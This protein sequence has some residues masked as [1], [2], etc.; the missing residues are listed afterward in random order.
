MVVFKCRACNANLNIEYGIK[1]VTCEF[2]GST[3]MIEK[4]YPGENLVKRGYMLL[5]DGDFRGAK[6][7]FD[8]ALDENS[9]ASEAYLGKVLVEN[10]VKKKDDFFDLNNISNV[11]EFLKNIKYSLDY[12]NAIRYAWEDDKEKLEN[13]KESVY[14]KAYDSA[15]ECMKKQD[16]PAA[17]D[18]LKRAYEYKDAPELLKE[19]EALADDKESEEKY[20][21]ALEYMKM[22]AYKNAVN[23]FDEL[24]EYKDSA[25]Q[26]KEC[27]YR[28]GE[29]HMK[30][31][32][33]MDA[34]AM[35]KNITEYKDA[36]ELLDICENIV[37][38]R[39]Y[40]YAKEYL[41]NSGKKKSVEEAK[42]IFM[43]MP[44]YKDCRAMAEICDKELMYIKAKDSMKKRFDVN[45]CY[46]CERE[47]MKIADYK[48]STELAKKCRRRGGLIKFVAIPSICIVF[49]VLILLLTKFL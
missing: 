40:Q 30:A 5:E 26:L 17:A 34:I 6:S 33:Y 39:R 36:A 27:D 37:Y 2:C 45:E 43:E 42:E 12:K 19:C 3:Q 25:E 41:E 14:K 10:E 1:M 24:G 8:K 21:K 46:S 9:E 22:G 4:R 31:E 13:F 11:G 15:V 49:V 38:E 20:Q 35:F 7:Y 32:D 29:N 23:L 48:D 28:C 18:L 16:Y 47:F 44:D